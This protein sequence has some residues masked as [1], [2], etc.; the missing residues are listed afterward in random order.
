MLFEH[1]FM[2]I[3]VIVIIVII[4]MAMAIFVVMGVVMGAE[5][6]LKHDTPLRLNFLI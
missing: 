6:F 1:L 5:G 2:I 3:V 4:A